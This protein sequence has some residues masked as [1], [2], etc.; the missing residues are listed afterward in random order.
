MNDI[1]TEQ[2]AALPETAVDQSKS[3]QTDSG[4]TEPR[5]TAIEQ[6]ETGHPGVDEVLSSLETLDELPVDRH[7]AVFEAAHVGL[8]DALKDARDAAPAHG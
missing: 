7:V 8:R 2:S 1:S 3:E 5:Q 4:Q 6:T